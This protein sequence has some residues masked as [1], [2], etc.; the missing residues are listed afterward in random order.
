MTYR[1]ITEIPYSFL[2]SVLVELSKTYPFEKIY[3]DPNGEFALFFH[4]RKLS[5]KEIQ[6][7]QEKITPKDVTVLTPVYDV[8]YRQYKACKGYITCIYS[9]EGIDYTKL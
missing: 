6:S 4:G 1:N 3:I 8:D 7:I 5:L 2:K 9:K